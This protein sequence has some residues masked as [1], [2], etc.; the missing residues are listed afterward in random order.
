M[1]R[2]AASPLHRA[3]GD[4]LAL[5]SRAQGS[6]TSSRL[7]HILISKYALH[8]I[9]ACVVPQDADMRMVLTTGRCF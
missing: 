4:E 7:D 6:D 2:N 5:P 1:R 3:P 8:H 9:F